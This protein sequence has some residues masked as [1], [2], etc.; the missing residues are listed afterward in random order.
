SP[1]RS[2]LGGLIEAL[3]ASSAGPPRRYDSVGTVDPRY[4]DPSDWQR[5]GEGLAGRSDTGSAVRSGGPSGLPADSSGGRR[6]ASTDSRYVGKT[7]VAPRS[8][9]GP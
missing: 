7:P 1:R 8:L 4:F 9:A 2:N 6:S 5:W 3:G